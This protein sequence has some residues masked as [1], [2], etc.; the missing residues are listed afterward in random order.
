MRQIYRSQQ[1]LVSATLPN[2]RRPIRLVAFH[3]CC[4]RSLGQDGFHNVPLSA[5]QN[6]YYENYTCSYS[7]SG[8]CPTPRDAIAFPPGLRMV[9]G[10]SSRRT[11]DLSSQWDQAILFDTPNGEI[12]GLPP[13]LSSR[14][15]ADVRFPSCW[16]GVNLDSADHQSH[17]AYPDPSLG[18]NTQGGMCPS[19]HPV[20]LISIGSEF[21]FDLQGVTD[22]TSLVFSNGDTTGYGFHADFLQG[23]T[24]SKALQDS[25]ANCFTNDDCPW[26]SFDAPDGIAPN[27]SMQSPE[28]APIYEEIG[29]NGPIPTLPGDNPVY[30]AGADAMAISVPVSSVALSSAAPSTSSASIPAIAVSS[31]YAVET[32]A[33][34]S[35]T[36]SQFSM[37]TSVPMYSVPGAI[38]ITIMQTEIETV[39]ATATVTVS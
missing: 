2:D 36:S 32:S 9:A 18:G 28:V 11:L 23:W 3:G 37:M 1:L 15:Q 35:S 7:P 16:D 12:Y 10:N 24:N 38:Y 39:T 13:T 19:S 4:K 6:S 17:V 26:N 21:G 20:A 34:A 33:G 14:L 27:P 5:L 31:V 25:F 8:V 29:L 30:T 22:P